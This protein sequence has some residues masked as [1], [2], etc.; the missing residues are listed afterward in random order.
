M[1]LARALRAA[2]DEPAASTAA[3]EVQVLATAKGD[4]AMLRTI[5]TFLEGLDLHALAREGG[6]A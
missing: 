2:G 3:T 4:E 5:T 6:R 1:A